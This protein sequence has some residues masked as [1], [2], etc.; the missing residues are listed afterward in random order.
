MTT[1]LGYTIFPTAVGDCAVAWNGVGLLG[2]WL[3]ER[4]AER[5]R[6][7]IAQRHP[8]ISEATTSGATAEAVA[9][10]TALLGGERLD[11][12]AVGIDDSALDPFDRRVY[13]AARQI[14][15][16]RVLTYGGLAVTIDLG[17]VDARAIGQSLGR[18]PFPIVV[19]CHRIVGAHGGL[20]GFSAPGGA[21]TKR[22][23]LTIEDARL[24]GTA[25]LFD[26]LPDEAP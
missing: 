15:P 26:M 8:G 20:G 25:D 1:S 4:S 11:L 9:A 23:L 13:A 10:I 22:L 21:A 7:R 6:A 12:S 18:N 17:P 19:P 2:V 5:L 14:P 24:A 16:G 3:P